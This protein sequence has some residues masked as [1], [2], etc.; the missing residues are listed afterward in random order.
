MRQDRAR[1]K[2]V[3]DPD[4]EVSARLGWPYV[5]EPTGLSAAVEQKLPICFSPSGLFPG[6][7]AAGFDFLCSWLWEVK[8]LL[9]GRKL[10]AV[11][12]IWRYVPTKKDPPHS[13]ALC[14]EEGRKQQLDLLLVAQR[15]HKVHDSIRANLTELYCF[16]QHDSYVLDVLESDGY[17][18]REEVQGLKYPGGF[19]RRDLTREAHSPRATGG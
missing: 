19:L 18:R 16:Q 1:W 12:E 7:R 2:V 13:F 5:T 8:D 3:F 4:L 10:L 9:P 6:E 17:F 11:D 15:Y 14:L